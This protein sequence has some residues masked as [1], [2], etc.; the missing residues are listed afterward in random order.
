MSEFRGARGSN[1][2]D[3]YHELW[4]TRHAIRLLDD[5]DPLQ[6]LA[7]EGLALVDEQSAS[8]TVW[9]GVD[10][11]LYEG[12]RNAAEASRIVVEQLKYSAANPSGSWTI[13]RL[14]QG[15]R[16][17]DAVV[18]RLA[19]AWSGLQALKPKGTVEIKLVTNQQ[20]AAEVEA[21]VVAIA[22]GG[23]AP[24]RKRPDPK[25]ADEAKLAF[26]TG[27]TKY[28][29]PGFAD[30]LRFE[31]GTGS[32]FA[33]E[34]QVLSDLTGWTD[35]ELQQVVADLRQFIRQ[36][37]RPEFAGELITKEKVLL[38]LRLSNIGALFPCPP[39]LSR[40]TQPVSR[41]SVT[42]AAQRIVAG[43]KRLC[44]HGPGGI[45]KTTALQEIETALPA[46]SVMIVFDCYGGGRY[47][48]SSAL[49]HR[50]IDAF[51]QL[52]NELATS[53]RLPIL[54]GRHQ[55]S[56][57]ARLF[58]NRLRHAAQAHGAQYPD[59]LIVIA[60]DAADNAVTAAAVRKPAEPCFVHD[61]VGLGDL[62]ANVRFVVTA[63]TGR[64]PEIGLPSSFRT[65]E[66]L[67]FTRAETAEH[68][69]RTWDAPPPWID[70]FHELT[71]GVPRVQAYAMDLG[72]DAPEKAI[73]RLLP[74]G[75][76]LDQ[77]FREQFER[78]LGKNGIP[79]DVAKFSAGL[80][81]L[82]RPVP[83]ADLSG[84]LGIPQPVLVDI[85]TDMAPAIRLNSGE[86]SFADEDFEH[87]VR[88]EGA[89]ALPEVTQSAA[90]WLLGRCDADD[91]AAQHVAG[92]LVAAGRGADLLDLVEREPAPAAVSDPVQRR[93][94]E[95]TRLRLA[96]SVC[97]TADDPARALRF[98]LIGGEGL[99]TERALRALLSDNPDLAVQFA[100]ETAGRLILGDPD[101]V[102]KHGAFLLHKQALDAA[103]DDR[104]SLREGRRLIEAWMAARRDRLPERRG[105]GWRLDISDVAASVEALLRAA[106]PKGALE[107][108]W[109]WRPKRLRFKV[110][111]LLVPRLLA[112][113]ET[114]LVRTVLDTGMLQP[115]EEIFVL[116][117]MAMAGASVN[118]GRL[119]RGLEMIRKRR[120]NIARFFA[121]SHASEAPL[122]TVL[123]V[124]M[125]ACELL[126]HHRDADA[127]VDDFLADVLRPVNR[128]VAIHS[129][130]DTARLD[131][132]FR[133]HA[134]RAA[135]A[136]QNP[137]IAGLYEPRPKSEG[138]EARGRSA[139]HEEEADRKLT[140]LTGLVFPVY[141]ATAVALTGAAKSV[142]LNDLLLAAAKRCEDDHWRLSRSLG[143][144][145]LT[146]AAARSML[147][148]L[149]TD[150]DPQM[151]AGLARRIHG[152]WGAADLAP[153]E[154]F[155]R[156]L[157][158]CPS[159]HLLL[160]S[161][162]DKA[163]HGIRGR[164]IGADDKSKSLVR[165]ARLL[166]PL[167]RDDANAVFND[168]VEAASQLDREIIPQ[169]RLLGTLFK[170]GLDHVEDRRCAARDLS[171]VLADASIR[172]D[173]GAELPWDEVLET[174]AALDFPL[175][176]A[177]VAKW[178]DAD[179]AGF[180]HTLAPVLKAGMASGELSPAAAMALDLL[181]NGDHQVIEAALSQLDDSGMAPFLEEA[182]WDAL[183][184]HNHRDNKKLVARVTAAGCCG[185]W[186]T[187]MKKRQAF[188]S[189]LPALARPATA[190]ARGGGH[191]RESAAVTKPSWSRDI[192]L[193]AEALDR[194]V[195]ATLEDVRG[196][197]E[198]ISAS[199]VLGWAAA[200]V[201][202]RDRVA[203][204]NVLHVS[205]V[206]IGGEIT[207]KLLELLDQ[208]NSPAIRAWATTALPKVIVARLPE[209]IR[210]IAHGETSLPR[211]I[212]W[213]RAPATRTVDL[214][215]RGVEL[216]GQ[217]LGGDQ[218]FALAGLIAGHLDKLAAASLGIWY[219]R[220]L[221][222][223][224][225]P[226]DRDQTWQQSAVPVTA[227]AAVGRFLF[228]CMGD[229][230]VRVRWRAVY[231]VRRLARLGASDEL[232][233]LIGEYSRREETVFRSPTLDFY[234][235]A[236]RLWFALA[237]DR[238]AGEAPDMGALAGQVLHTTALDED[239]P[240]VFVRS[241]A[242]DACLKLVEAGK[243]TLSETALVEL[244]MVAR[245]TLPPHAPPKRPWEKPRGQGGDA[246][247]RF[248]FDS[249]DTIPYW[250]ERV[251]GGFAD[252]S[253]ERLLSVAERW[254]LDRWGYPGKIR[255]FD[256]ERRRHR[257]ADRDWSLSSNR[258]G[259]NPTLE[260]LNTHLEWHALWCAAGEL[261]RT[262][263]LVANEEPD[264][265]ELPQRIRRE[266]L[267][268]PPLW[269]TDLRGPV[270]LRPD[271]WRA[272][273]EPVPG[274]VGSMRES[275]MR[276]E[277]EPKDC[278]DYIMVAGGWQIRTHD[279]V[280]T[281]S[282]C[283]ALVE[284]TVADALLRA[285]QSM[286]SA[287]DYVLPREGE[288]QNPDDADKSPYRMLP[289]LRSAN[290][291]GGI[292][293][294]DPLRG[295]AALVDWLPGQRV[296]R[297]CGLV[298]DDAGKIAWSAP[299][300]APMFL[301]EVWGERDR[302]DDSYT[303]S[304]AVSGR[305]LLV[306][307]TQL[308]KF[309][310]G[311]GLDL[312]IEVEVRREGRESRRSYDSEDDTPAA[313]YDRVYRLDGR[314]GVHIAEGRIGTWAGDCPPA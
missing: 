176:L 296:Q 29:L 57:P 127:L 235:L 3:D 110:A 182:A 26:A 133:A 42:A 86:V 276:A 78:A 307:R 43:E 290:S 314:G 146:M 168:A 12:G 172:L 277:L 183:I 27:L 233:A 36:R 2:G 47:L 84:V 310:Q 50:P 148:L 152:R 160:V 274:W 6:A 302:D 191:E 231:A 33:I 213:S 189:S 104:I 293:D 4:A 208:W 39:Q 175:A 219:A 76:S 124:A 103:R 178:D 21:A 82:A 244:K 140:E 98:V 260:R 305:R 99:R 230:D 196:G 81:A 147:V 137:D 298:R 304:M 141:A 249:M 25:A 284:P 255:A 89:S 162:I 52:S 102:G 193:D 266:M 269:S 161:D 217:A 251:L 171:E 165:Y 134:L 280:E 181:L 11:T 246:G 289:W 106:G 221:A 211:A 20:I 107:S 243:L 256:A 59:A 15:T 201:A 169:L 292:D 250:Y 222:D 9:D 270:P 272:P 144:G 100:P 136:G 38:G 66:I 119:A 242:R 85:C 303:T 74:N 18:N 70:A 130:G 108:L 30:A 54:L 32:R 97:R 154:A 158:L 301:Y 197:E 228:A 179:L 295:S 16:R 96:I 194:V 241:F 114:D 308:M 53:L 138:K 215:L 22:K 264:W 131:L 224:I 239:F 113:G 205:K 92:A 238:V 28:D 48:D 116:V 79:S 229:Y 120:L 311:E 135:R 198:F 261:M 271:F 236:A 34:E 155:A 188:V 209:F 156:R 312:V 109:Q 203:F 285:L 240:H 288:D 186:A 49:R 145:A 273:Q 10:C 31:G 263:P 167:S 123:D 299:G 200:S 199:E 117:P 177:N 60:V 262:E 232:E 8:E 214:L 105:S 115:W 282:V 166:L 248:E 192:L 226:E 170:R 17:A 88:E 245:S 125:T 77:V 80:I 128:R 227:P 204:L 185:R 1:T 268:E 267:T 278:A 46:H 112:E 151:L 206:G 75:R 65:E 297:A 44:L 157:A 122:S 207:D 159:L 23:V 68:V 111:T 210:Y 180:R 67:P 190:E 64:L 281:V 306:D 252:V 83:L 258:H 95:L 69:R 225:A 163:V 121:T 139:Y 72:D 91:Y 254:I 45:G 164:R 73:D 19:R 184:R 174:L 5:R 218:I 40:I 132:L 195:K 51:L 173:G 286:E 313:A 294:L 220:R 300:R 71:G 287:W 265:G 143:G 283:S 129:P 279:R 153:D 247:R 237:W 14:V 150:E 291:D 93:E 55:V 35:L 257:F 62:P 24:T 37:M 63:R 234:W 61:F 259:S 58:A 223:R 126:V 101:H 216:H 90:T 202:V 13:A 56:D 187:A 149:A 253:L 142:A 7:V 275:Q 309:L 94:A 212:E 87:F 41:M 118:M